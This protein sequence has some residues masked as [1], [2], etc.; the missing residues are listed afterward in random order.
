MK[1]GTV[2]QKAG[3]YYVSIL[4][5]VEETQVKPKLE[6]TGLGIDLGIKDFAICSN[7]EVHENINKTG[8]VRK[9][10]RKL[11]REQRSLSRKYKNLKKRGEKSA[12]NKRANIDKNILRVQ[13]LH[14]SVEMK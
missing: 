10:E 13:K 12:T 3:R 14:A 7:G 2:S 6:E 8:K 1:S 4:C 5:E 9:L 11:K